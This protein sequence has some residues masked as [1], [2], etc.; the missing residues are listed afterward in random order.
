M[1]IIAGTIVTNSDITKNYK[2]CR[3]QAESLGKLF[4]FKNNEPD[5]VLFSIVEYEKYSA[6]IEYAEYLDTNGIAKLLD[7]IPKD[8]NEQNYAVGLV[9]KDMDQ[10]IAV[11][12]IK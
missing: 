12:I 7:A 3:D 10:I 6:I 2:A 4:I 5:A 1:K 11:D 9:R 8:G